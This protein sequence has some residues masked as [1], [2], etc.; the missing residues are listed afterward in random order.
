MSDL[1]KNRCSH[2]RKPKEPEEKLLCCGGC[3]QTNYC[4][5]ECQKAAWSEHKT[6][7]KLLKETKEQVLADAENADPSVKATFAPSYAINLPTELARND[8]V[9]AAAMGLMQQ[10]KFA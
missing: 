6:C 1:F 2:C 3:R 9:T 7:C 8:P 4:S 10:Q 5:V